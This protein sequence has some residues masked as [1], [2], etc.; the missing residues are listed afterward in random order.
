[1][2]SDDGIKEIHRVIQNMENS[3]ADNIKLYGANNEKRLSGK[4][5]TS[6]YKR[7]TWGIGN[8]GVSVRIN[9]RTHSSGCGYFED[10]RPAANM[11]P[12]MVTSAIMTNVI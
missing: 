7:F 4:N 12:Y 2:R 3:H 9:N 11:D 8:R 5:E 1:M 10:R 6:D